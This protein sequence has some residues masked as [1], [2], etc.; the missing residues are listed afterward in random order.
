MSS[1]ELLFHGESR[2]LGN[3]AESVVKHFPEFSNIELS[4]LLPAYRYELEADTNDISRQYVKQHQLIT[5]TRLDNNY[6]KEYVSLDKIYE[7][8]LVYFWDYYF[9]LSDEI[10]S[11]EAY[12]EQKTHQVFVTA[13]GTALKSVNFL[14]MIWLTEEAAQ[15]LNAGRKNISHGKNVSES[16][17][18]SFINAYLPDKISLINA[19]ALKNLYYKLGGVPVQSLVYYLMLTGLSDFESESY[20][21]FL[22]VSK[23]TEDT[24]PKE[25]YEML[26]QVKPEVYKSLLSIDIQLPE[27]LPATVTG[28]LAFQGD[29]VI[30]NSDLNTY[31]LFINYQQ[32][33]SN[34]LTG[35]GYKQ[36]KLNWSNTSETP[37]AARQVSFD[38]YRDNGFVF[39]AKLVTNVNLVLKLFDGTVVWKNKYDFNKIDLLQDVSIEVPFI[40]AVALASLDYSGVPKVKS[41]SGKLADISGK[42]T[43]KDVVVVLQAK[44]KNGDGEWVVVGQATTDAQGGFTMPYPNGNY[45]EA[46]ILTS[47]SPDNPTSVAINDDAD[48]QA[49]QVTLSTDFIHVLSNSENSAPTNG[50]KNG[51]AD[52]ACQ[53]PSTPRLPSHEELINSDKYSQDM[54]GGCVNLTVPN[55]TLSEQS[56][57]AIVRTS[58]PDVA[59][60]VLQKNNQAPDAQGFQ[61][62][63]FTLGNGVPIERDEVSF[64]NLIRWQDAP[65]SLDK[66]NHLSIYQAT[67]VAHGHLLHYKT[68]VKADG[69]SLGDL[70]YSLPLAPGQKKQIVVYDWNRTLQGSETQQLS[71]RESLNA[72]ISNDRTLIDNLTGS[73]NESIRGQSSAK[74]W[75][76]SGGLGVGAMIGPVSL[77]VGVAGGYASSSSQASQD[78]SRNTS[79]A[80]SE[81]LKNSIM[82]SATSYREQNATL[83]DTVKEGQQYSTTA[84]TIANHN[85]CHSLTMLYF[86]VLRH[87]AVYQELAQVEE[88]I[89]VPLVMT[90]F[91][92]ENIHKWRDVLAKNLLYR[93]SSTYFNRFIAQ[94]PLARAFDANDRVI[95]NW[96]NADF[97]Q[98]RYCDEPIRE[99]TGTFAIYAAIPRPLTRF[100]RILS[101]P[102][103][104]GTSTSQGGIDVMGTIRDNLVG[105]VVGALTFGL[106]GG[107]SVRRTTNEKKFLTCVKIFDAFMTMDDN[108]NSVSPAR[109]I[110][111][112][113]MEDKTVKDEDGNNVTVHFFEKGH[114]DETLWYAY[115]K[116]LGMPLQEL[117]KK[118]ENNVIADWD[119][120]FYT[121]LAPRILKRLISENTLSFN[122]GKTDITQMNKYT[123]PDQRINYRFTS[124]PTTDR[125]SIDLITIDY[126]R[127]RGLDQNELSMLKDRLTIRLEDISVQYVTSHF[128]GQIYQGYRGD[129]L[130][131]D[132][133]QGTQVAGILT[134]MNSA[135]T[136]DPRKED[137]FIVNELITHLNGNLEYYNK[138]LWANLDADRRFMLLD[139]FHI[140]VF[141]DNNRPTVYKSLASIVKNQLITITGNSLVFPVAA[142]V[143]VD[144]SYVIVNSANDEGQMAER[145]MTLFDHYRPLTPTPPYRIS[146]PTRGVFAEA[147]Q[148]SCNACEKVEDQ[149]SQDW[150]KF[151]TEEPTAIGTVTVPT[152]EATDWKAAFKDFATPI[153][154]IQNAPAAPAPGAGL[155]GV[156]DLLGK[157]GI[158]KDITGLDGNQKN[159]MATYQSNQEN[160]KAFAQMAKEMGMQA[161]NTENADKIKNAISDAKS[162]GD[163]SPE[164]A[165][166]LTKAHI[167]QMIDGG[168]SNKAEIQKTVSSKPS[169]TDAAVQA[170]NQGKSVKA[171]NN[172]PITGKSEQ[173]EILGSTDNRVL[174][175]VKGSIIKLKQENSNACWATVATMMMSWKLQ[176]TVSVETVLS[177]AGQEYVDK[178]K[179][180]KGLFAQE[181]QAFISA[182]KMSGENKGSYPLQTYIDLINTYGPLWVTTDSQLQVNNLAVHARIL[183]KILGTGT[184]DGI[185]TDFIFIDP[186]SGTEVRESFNQFIHAFEQVVADNKNAELFIQIVHFNDKSTKEG[187]SDE[188]SGPSEGSVPLDKQINDFNQLFINNNAEYVLNYGQFGLYYTFC[189]EIQKQ[190]DSLKAKEPAN[191]AF[192]DD[193]KIALTSALD[194]ANGNLP[195]GWEA[196]LISK[197]YQNSKD[198]STWDK[199]QPIGSVKG[200]YS[201]QQYI[202]RVVEVQ[203]AYEK[204]KLL[205]AEES[206]VR[207][208]AKNLLHDPS[209]TGAK[210]QYAISANFLH[211]DSKLEAY[212]FSKFKA[213][214]PMAIAILI[215]CGVICG[216]TA[217]SIAKKIYKTKNYT[218]RVKSFI[219]GIN[220]TVNVKYS[221]PKNTVLTYDKGKLAGAISKIKVLLDAGTLIVAG[222]LSGAIKEGD[223]PATEHYILI[224]GYE[225]NTFAFWDPDAATTIHPVYG[226]GIGFLYF[227][228]KNDRFS[229]GQDLDDLLKLE[230]NTYHLRDYDDTVGKKNKRHRYQ[231]R[232]L[233]AVV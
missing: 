59:N 130:L 140:Q 173:I 56:Y 233:E 196:V 54:G 214:I 192:I 27:V 44:P 9:N 205:P 65:E 132:P 176:T 70:I 7:G 37:L 218:P 73:I 124:N 158:F 63:Y 94:N 180:G 61:P 4:F 41:L 231:V 125:K 204:I 30:L 225:N 106:F 120:I 203:N 143:K 179:A 213:T 60:F 86:E 162:S 28:N 189:D 227:D 35:A 24:F 127:P 186:A 113:S 207:A 18:I 165:N 114:D 159:V 145:R 64:D 98:G 128:R 137:K 23:E 82:Q 83:I 92:R 199:G 55:R 219:E 39:D 182:L 42:T 32:T 115:A 148:G 222:V 17:K 171:L 66:D 163:I 51:A 20:D 144:R 195:K 33:Q 135:E 40:K 1:I 211:K 175:E 177:M 11:I 118:F 71:Q 181:K 133:A 36:V 57:Y 89:F 72:S 228:D 123:L 131:D 201:L 216:D 75:G 25:Y 80:F 206:A 151:K 184:A 90:N 38:F 102:V 34:H 226:N 153:V 93:P 108:F 117:L 142:G 5:S 52:C 48:S 126:Q 202:D 26:C 58:D 200:E 223:H 188:A 160:A 149:T 22:S 13:N 105:S 170:A 103:G 209:A 10:D 15:L 150:E 69:Y 164:D 168:E 229:T 2:Y 46:R 62:V 232:T 16:K 217:S 122:F 79:Q 156:S 208:A 190:I 8:R 187:S 12:L 68:I 107:P 101:L 136:A 49:A 109:C 141:D 85:H 161:H 78:S 50:A 45:T 174:A 129:D 111:V 76:V 197:A 3:N 194:N 198:C 134:P 224:F 139:G 121:E 193:V 167:Q 116:L 88:C 84:E 230:A 215:D 138:V 77:V 91:T 97:P 112:T 47:L 178:F 19:D 29:E 146:V 99:V 166:K 154:N 110:R 191:N 104:T 14:P 172:D 81:T 169:L 31:D 74:T 212:D 221:T 21:E 147:V 6:F 119:K 185:G 43:L 210:A 152:P 96:S 95:T 87:Y 53:T 67:S 155:A 183:T 220:P 157:S 100:D